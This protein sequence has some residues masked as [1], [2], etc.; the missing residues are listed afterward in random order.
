MSKTPKK[1]K[2]HPMKMK[3]HEAVDH[4]FHPKIAKALKQHVLEHNQKPTRK[5]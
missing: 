5:G 1:P 4:L 2:K 3:T